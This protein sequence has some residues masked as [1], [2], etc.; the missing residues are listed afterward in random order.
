MPE[1]LQLT[2]NAQFF[3]P[4]TQITSESILAVLNA[5]SENKVDGSN[6]LV[7]KIRIES[8][9]PETKNQY[10]YSARIFASKRPVYF[11]SEEITDTI[12]AFIVIIEID[13]HIAIL[14][15]SCANTSDA[16][17]QYFN[18]I[19]SNLL[20][21]TFDDDAV[22]FQKI[23]LRNMTISDRALRARSYEAADL[24]GLLSTHAAGRSIPYFLK[25]RQGHSHKTISAHSGRVVESSERKGL[26]EIASWVKNQIYLIQNPATNKG[27]LSSFAKLVELEQ[28]LTLTTPAA[29]LI[30]SSLLHD[31]LIETGT[32]VTYKTR[33]GR[34]IPLSDSRKNRLIQNLEVVYD[35]N[36]DL[37]IIGHERTSK[38]RKNAKSISIQ[39]KPLKQIKLF[40]NGKELSIQ[41]YIMKNGLFSVCFKDPKFMYF[42]GRCFEDA[43]GISEIQSILDILNP[44]TSFSAITSEKGSMQPDSTHFDLQS[45]FG[46]VETLHAADDYIFC[47]DLG[48]EW[49]DHITLNQDQSCISFIHSKHGS[50]SNSAS[51]L[52]DLVGQGIKNLGN[53]YFTIDGM[54][55]KCKNKFSEMY[56]RDGI[57]SQINRTRKGDVSSIENY[58]ADLLKDYRLYRKCV[59]SCSFLSKQEITKEFNKLTAGKSVSGNI[60]QL[61]W[62]IS[63]FAHAAKDMNVIPEIYCQP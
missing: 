5:A 3:T 58:L 53:M 23:S 2:Q 10:V 43:S 51:N 21:A 57:V 41:K 16:T 24:K 56:A 27:F 13:N 61:L 48:N 45:M 38:L 54:R 20:T 42:M 29:V 50:K 33:R 26:D 11:F 30:E 31:H 19:N 22:D 40:E 34:V 1:R 60:I 44:K 35:V 8:T 18:Q 62:I 17:D 32:P 12:H 25:I 7:E 36:D 47:D 6:F 49:A 9:I 14:K 52:H 4:K 15:K 63:S 59:L 46:E 55:A 37:E 28:V 39:S